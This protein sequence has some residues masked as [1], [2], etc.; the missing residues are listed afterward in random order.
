[1]EKQNKIEAVL[2]GNSLFLILILLSFFNH[3]N[4]NSL[5]L[6][7]GLFFLA[8]FSVFLFFEIMLFVELLKSK[9]SPENSK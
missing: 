7:R 4:G 9:D 1:M 2:V 3:I 5:E 6:W 8:S